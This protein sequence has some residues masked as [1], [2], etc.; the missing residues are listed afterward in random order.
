[1]WGLL[2]GDFEDSELCERNTGL[3]LFL[4]PMPIHF[5]GE[6]HNFPV[7]G[8]DARLTPEN[9]Q[10]TPNEYTALTGE[11]PEFKKEMQGEV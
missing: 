7:G 2:N 1:M 8:N 9:S 6:K 3:S 10:G 4:T 5:T 11:V